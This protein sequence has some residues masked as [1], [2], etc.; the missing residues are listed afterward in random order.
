MRMRATC[1]ARRP[2]VCPSASTTYHLRTISPS[3]GKYV[4]MKLS[5]IEKAAKED[6]SLILP[7][8]TPGPSGGQ[9]HDYQSLYD[10]LPCKQMSTHSWDR[11]ANH[12]VSLAP[13]R[14]VTPESTIAEKMTLQGFSVRSPANTCAWSRYFPLPSHRME[15][16]I[17][18]LGLPN[19][20]P[21]TSP[22]F[23]ERSTGP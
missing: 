17:H 18:P 15:L 16:P 5:Q 11:S 3:L 13:E 6:R 23:T 10:S 20:L 1:E 2:S 8:R 21:L 4:D 22:N 9:P 7:T 14:K 12:R 19:W